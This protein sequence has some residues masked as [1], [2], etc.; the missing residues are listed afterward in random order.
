M[1]DASARL[2]VVGLAPGAQGA[3]RTGRPFHGDGSGGPLFRA[4][5]ETGFASHP[6][7]VAD[8]R[9]HDVWITN[10]VKC[11]PPGNSPSPTERRACALFLQEED[12]L[13]PVKVVVA[14]GAVAWTAALEVLGGPTPSPR[15]RF[16]HLAEAA[17]DRSTLVGSYHPS[18][19]NTNTGRL[20][21]PMLTAVFGR[22]R[23]LLD[24]ASGGPA[25][26]MR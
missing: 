24:G 22:A 8:L 23:Q 18:R 26:G 1:G 2:L 9:L 25:T 17:L 4:L 21:L 19:Q 6:A 16:G 5:H 11:V 7:P 20:T 13:L 15:P 12:R 3:N 14:L 10:A